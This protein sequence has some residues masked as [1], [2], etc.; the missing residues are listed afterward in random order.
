M[1][2][3]EAN[4]PETLDVLDVD[5][6]PEQVVTSD[7]YDVIESAITKIEAELRRTTE[8]S[9]AC[10]LTIAESGVIKLTASGDWI[11]TLPDISGVERGLP[12][13]VYKADD[14]NYR[15]TIVPAEDQTI[16]GETS[17]TELN[18]KNSWVYLKSDIDGWDIIFKDKSLDMGEW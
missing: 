18:Y 3:K 17:Y 2:K 6:Q 8:K 16:A 13:L 9:A 11:L 14:N 7:S 10:I 5:R 1:A 12:F 4:F 15:I